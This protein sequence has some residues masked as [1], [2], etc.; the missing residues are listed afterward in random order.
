MR[1]TW[2]SRAA[3][4]LALYAGAYVVLTL[5]DADPEPFGLLLLTLVV[6]ATATLVVDALAAVGPTWSVDDA[7]PEHPPCNDAVLARNIRIL[8]HHLTGR[9]PDAALRDLLATL[10]RER[11]EQVHG[12][13]LDHAHVRERLGPALVAVIEE[14]PRRLA[15]SEIEAHIRRIEE[16]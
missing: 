3:A 16:L 8:Q 5:L 1:L 6:V 9:E 15:A 2:W 10:A 4:W 14:P 12:L 11:A 7:S 13:P